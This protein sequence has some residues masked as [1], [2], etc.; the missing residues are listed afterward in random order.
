MFPEGKKYDQHLHFRKIILATVEENNAGGKR[1][2]RRLL[3]S[4]E[5]EMMV[6]RIKILTVIMDR[7]KIN[8]N[9]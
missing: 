8:D 4:S 7:F 3:Y 5:V 9:Y 2:F 6:V 1:C